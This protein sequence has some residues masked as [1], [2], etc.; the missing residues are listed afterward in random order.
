MEANDMSQSDSTITLEVFRFRPDQE[1]EP[2]FQKYDVPFHEDWDVGSTAR[3]L[4]V[5]RVGWEFA[6]VV[7]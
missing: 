6:E 2:T 3:S 5:G 1:D 4:T 7:G